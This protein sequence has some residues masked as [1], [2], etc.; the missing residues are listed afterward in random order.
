MK[1][2]LNKIIEE[3]TGQ[4]KT[5]TVQVTYIDFCK[6]NINAALLLSQLMYWSNKSKNNGWV[7]KSASDWYNELRL[8]KASL[9][10]AV[11][12]LKNLDIIETKL[13]KANGS[14]TSHYKIK[15]GFIEKF[16]TFLKDKVEANKQKINNSEIE[17]SDNEQIESEK[18]EIEK[19][20]TS[21]KNILNSENRISENSE[22][23]N[24]EYNIDYS[25]DNLNKLSSE[26]TTENNLEITSRGGQA[27]L[28]GISTNESSNKI[29][30][31]TEDN[32]N[33]QTKPKEDTII[34]EENNISSVENNDINLEQSNLGT[35]CA[36][37]STLSALKDKDNNTEQIDKNK[38][39][40]TYI[41][42]YDRSYNFDKFKSHYLNYF[43][44]I[45]GYQFP[46]D[47]DNKN[48]VFS[49]NQT[50]RGYYEFLLESDSIFDFKNNPR[51]R[52]NCFKDIT[53]E[54]EELGFYIKRQRGCR[55]I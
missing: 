34:S 10:T 9:N 21:Q 53:N 49:F 29:E 5:L 47:W 55:V 44:D 37:I 2:I 19:D 51:K 12:T 16:S 40:Y 20:S 17:L 52:I 46:L 31:Y 18:T 38:T 48:E 27:H 13:K 41:P 7:Y 22:N 54:L 15:D 39:S 11:K 6:G 1:D 32:F 43:R 8:K 33:N 3:F 23:Y 4:C 36:S 26:N 30:I 24:I 35:V 50:L 45:F 14:P 28:S 42:K 25:T